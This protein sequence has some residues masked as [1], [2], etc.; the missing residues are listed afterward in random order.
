MPEGRFS[1]PFSPGGRAAL[2][3][4]P[5]YHAAHHVTQVLFR[6]DPAVLRE[7]LPRPFVPDGEPGLALAS[8]LDAVFTWGDAGDTMPPEFHQCLE[9]FIMLPC[10]LGERRGKYYVAVYVDRDWIFAAAHYIGMPGKLARIQYTRLHPLHRH[11]NAPRPGLRLDGTVERAGQRVM[12]LSVT[13]ERRVQPEGLPFGSTHTEN[14]GVRQYPAV[15]GAAPYR[16][17]VRIDTVDR[18]VGDVWEGRGALAFGG[19]E[20]DRLLPMQ[21]REV[22]VGHF[23]SYAYTLTGVTVVSPS[24]GEAHAG[25]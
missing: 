9:A 18:A 3:P 11:L 24:E 17:I 2:A 14:F 23:A 20:L 12:T 25:R 16:D 13:L 6:A 19:S 1:P 5:P 8:V 10:R 15:K 7:L 22:L 4:P 21:P